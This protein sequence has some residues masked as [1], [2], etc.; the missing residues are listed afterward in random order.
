MKKSIY[1]SSSLLAALSLTLVAAELVYP[2]AGAAQ[3]KSRPVHAFVYKATEDLLAAGS[4]QDKSSQR[5]KLPVSQKVTGNSVSGAAR[6]ASTKRSTA[7]KLK[8]RQFSDALFEEARRD[9]KFI[10]L[11]LEAVWC[12]W[13][14]VMDKETYSNP[15]IVELIEKKFIPVKVDQDA[16]PDLSHKYEDYGWPATIVFNGKG[17][18]IVKRSGYI[19]PERMLRLLKAI[20]KDPSPE[21]KAPPRIAYSRKGALS[22]ELKKELVSRHVDGYDTK[23][24]A[25]GKF[26]KF[27]DWD[28]VEYAMELGLDGDKESESRAVKTLD[29]QLNLLDPVWGGIYQY[30]TDGDWKHPHFEKIMQ[31]QA[32]NIRIYS[33]GYCLYG[34]ESYLDA[35]KSIAGYLNRFLRS[36]EGAY[37][38]SQDADLEPGKHSAGFFDLSDKERLARGVPR[39]DKHIYSRENGWAINALT[40][41]YMVTGDKK[42]LD[43]ALKAANW[44][45][46]NRSIKDGGF[47]HDANDKSGPYLGDTLAMGRAFLSLYTATADRAWLKRAEQSVSFIQ[48]HFAAASIG[49]SQDGMNNAGYVTADLRSSKVARPVPL[50]D[51]N[52]ML[53]RFANLLYHYSGRADAKGMALRAMR[54]L[55][56]PEVA[57]R[58]KI[59]VAGPLLADWELAR[60]PLHVTVVGSK[61]DSGALALFQAALSGPAIYRRVEWYDSK[62]GVL[63]NTEIE[64]PTL[65]KP[66]AFS[67]GNGICSTPVYEPKKVE[68]FFRPKSK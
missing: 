23:N 65:S 16:R 8:W 30:S 32:E 47:R 15:L 63:P 62:E 48:G 21:E 54:Y 7:K 55:A 60:D 13:C 22:K 56:T 51:E 66:A 28:S 24:G 1:L 49:S 39:V 36:P 6:G 25:W 68:K 2:L 17:E 57:K 4:M 50:P 18:E 27:L 11:D 45:I 53:A 52:V 67:C 34:K 38:T 61:T 12:H 31:M 3:E 42:Y 19:R 46:A 41:L 35:A 29:N 44:I 37:Y 5:S 20:I 43:D 14:H 9:N 58:R 64:Y 59:L 10:L 40:N 26:H 33:L